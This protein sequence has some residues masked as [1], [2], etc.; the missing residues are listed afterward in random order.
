VIPSPMYPA[1]AGFLERGM[2]RS[3]GGIDFGEEDGTFGG[4][5]QGSSCMSSTAPVIAIPHR[6]L[7]AT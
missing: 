2:M 4:V 1:H 3:S 7:L 5:P 6:P